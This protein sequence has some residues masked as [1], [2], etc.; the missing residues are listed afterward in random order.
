M[1]HERQVINRV[2]NIADFG[3]KPYP[4]SKLKSIG[5]R[6]LFCQHFSLDRDLSGG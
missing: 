2:G 4:P 6:D 3:H 1:A 5:E